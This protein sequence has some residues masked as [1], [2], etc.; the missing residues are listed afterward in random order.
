MKKKPQLV[1]LHGLFGA[2][3]G[4]N[5]ITAD[6]RQ[7]GYEVFVPAVPPFAGSE[8]KWAERASDDVD[9]DRRY[10]E[11]FREYFAENEIVHPVL[12][13]HSMGTLVAGSILQS[14]P[15]LVN[16]KVILLSPISRQPNT[17]I[18]RISGLS[19]YLPPKMTDWITT[20][21][22]IV[23]RGRKVFREILAEVNRC[24][25]DRRPSN[26]YIQEATRFSVGDT[27]VDKLSK[28]KPSNQ[29][30][31]LLLLA[32]EHDHLVPPKATRKAA[33]WL[34]ELPSKIFECECDFLV[35]TG[36]LH[37][38]EKP[39][40]TSRRIVEFLEK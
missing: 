10:A 29:R 24:S 4:L 32:G 22:L 38:Y 25:H 9:L 8:E 28:V 3:L 15:E 18:S 40:E 20:Q 2:P 14:Y 33:Q 21:F 13:G 6:L 34:N 7:A 23:P 35:Q 16:E 37:N 39:H 27:V 19:S 11:Y 31:Q 5:E 36:H 26:Y 12:I 1:L 30:F 17:L